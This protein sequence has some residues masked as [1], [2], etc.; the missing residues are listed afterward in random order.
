MT[1]NFD[2]NTTNRDGKGQFAPGRTGETAT[3]VLDGGDVPAPGTTTLIARDPNGNGGD[4]YRTEKEG[5]GYVEWSQG[6][7]NFPRFSQHFDAQGRQHRDDGPSFVAENLVEWSQ[8]GVTSRD[9]SEGPAWVESNGE[10]GYV[11]DNEH[12]NP[13][14]EQMTRHGVGSLIMDDGEVGYYLPG[15]PEAD[16]YEPPTDGSTL[17]PDIVQSRQARP[18]EDL[19]RHPRLAPHFHDHQPD[20]ESDQKPI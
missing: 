7:G 10:C 18:V 4:T 2:E 17:T 13:T 9:P 14:V 20:Y 19:W 8:H 5:G 1:A 11:V 16:R 3:D 15:T 6:F 12:V